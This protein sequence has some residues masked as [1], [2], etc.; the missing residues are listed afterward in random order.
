M[1]LLQ[2]ELKSIDDNIIESD[3][4]K[5]IIK[6]T[7]PHYKDSSINWVIY[8]LIKNKIITKLNN[9]EYII[10]Y[11]KEYKYDGLSDASRNLIDIFKNSFSDINIVVF[12]TFMLNE[13]I[14]HLISRN[15]VIVEVEKYFVNDIFRYIQNIYPNTRLN[16]SHEDLYLYKDITIVVNSLVTQAPINKNDKTVKIEKLIVDLFT[17]DIINEFISEN[18]KKE[19]IRSM[20]KNY[21][22]N[23][24]TIFAY[25]K[26]RKNYD[27]VKEVLDYIKISEK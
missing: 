19:V 23:D 27:I 15:I 2:K 9:R 10:G 21:V 8:K 13:W 20:I 17:K 24:K 11:L 4:L 25:T 22:V 5:E 26:R 16:P 6:R 3:K 1:N 7:Y 12:E 18:E 14:N